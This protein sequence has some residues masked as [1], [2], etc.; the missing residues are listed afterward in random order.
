MVATPTFLTEASSSAPDST[1][2]LGELMVM[3]PLWPVDS[4]EALVASSPS[5]TLRVLMMASLLTVTLS[6]PSGVL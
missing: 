1:T 4:T 3:L 5:A 6:P 2:M